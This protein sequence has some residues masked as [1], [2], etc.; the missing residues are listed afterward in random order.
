MVQNNP[1]KISLICPGCLKH[2]S[3]ITDKDSVKV[4]LN[5]ELIDSSYLNPKLL[6]VDNAQPNI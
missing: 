3:I 1:S 2:I 5:G 6:D 4:Y